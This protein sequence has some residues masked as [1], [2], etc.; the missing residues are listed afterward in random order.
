MRLRPGSSLWLLR[1]EVRMFFF[2]AS[3]GSKK[4]IARRGMGKGRIALWIAAFVVIHVFAFT[5]LFN[6]DIG[7]T[8]P[9]PVIAGL[10]GLFAAAASLMLSSG[11]KSSVEV[12]FTR[13]DL[14]LLL[15]SPLSSRGIFS[16]RLAGIVVGVASVFLFFLAPFAHAGLV[17]GQYRWLGIYPLVIGTAIIAA[18][19]SM[20]FTLGLA[21]VFG[22]RRTR[23][24]AQVFG[25]LAGAMFFLLSQAYSQTAG[26]VTRR[27]ADW[28]APLLAPGGALGPDKALWWPG[29]ALLGDPLPLIAIS[30]LALVTFTL[31]VRFT[32]AFFVH[33]VQ[34]AV[35]VV[36]AAAAPP[37]GQRYRFGRS[38]THAVIVKEWRLIVRDPQLISQV[39]L[40]LLYMLPLCFVLLARES[41]RMP[42]VGA[43]LTF[44]CGSLTTALA[45]VII[46]AEDAPDLLRASPS[47][48]ATIRRAKLAAVAMPALVIVAAP[49]LWVLTRDPR[50]AMVMF[51]TVAANVAASAL[52][53]LWC[54]RPAVRGEFK[55]RAKGNFLASVLEMLNGFAWAGL[56]FLLLSARAPAESSLPMLLGTVGLLVIAPAILFFGW[57]SRSRDQ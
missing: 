18:S 4:G 8:S 29:H 16:V 30:I 5:T 19:L 17:L 31:T 52:I 1:H 37:G 33:G 48:M 56:A 3:F 35:S 20:L 27:V 39:L 53:S 6:L 13:G 38:L 32:H 21:R 55:A 11:V 23:V 51:T 2:N 54:G 41:A 10:T 14:D 15:S 9:Q 43:S 7:A 26:S 47:S 22:V 44:L 25:A 28:L 24:V 42:G 57:L 45:W 36:R 34:Q 49:L 50:A 12:L 46:S 40:Q